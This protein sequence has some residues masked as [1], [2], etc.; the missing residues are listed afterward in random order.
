MNPREPK[1]QI[2]GG[3]AAWKECESYRFD[4][5]MQ[6][7]EALICHVSE[8][9]AASWTPQ[10]SWPQWDTEAVAAVGIVPGKGLKQ[11]GLCVTS[12]MP[13]DSVIRAIAGVIVMSMAFHTSGTT[14]TLYFEPSIMTAPLVSRKGLLNISMMRFW[15][16][17]VEAYE[18][19]LTEQTEPASPSSEVSQGVPPPTETPPVQSTTLSTEAPQGQTMALGRLGTQGGTLERVKEA[20]GLVESG[21]P[22]TE[23]CKR[24]HTD[25]RTYDRYVAEVMDWSI[26][27]E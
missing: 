17:L 18:R 27:D 21:I 9:G 12:Q 22:K 26:D 11:Y 14:A 3:G 16:K 7:V 5:H 13:G 1:L 23:A 10:D 25:P 24:A 2:E 19:Q 4:L 8:S 20:R 6:K 15:R